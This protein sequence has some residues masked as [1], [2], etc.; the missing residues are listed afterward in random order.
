MTTIVTLLPPEFADWE[1]ALINGAGRSFYGFETR[2]ATPDGA[3]VTSMGGLRV[4][5]DMG[6]AELDP[7]TFDVLLICGGEGWR[8]GAEVGDIAARAHAAGKVVGAI[9]DGVWALAK[10]GL[11]DTRPHTGN[12]AKEVADSGYAG[13]DFYSDAPGAVTSDGIITAAGTAPVAFMAA[14]MTALGKGNAELD[15]YVG[16][17]KAQFENVA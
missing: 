5:P 6:F 17:H 16:L 9:C 1:T 14:V 11:I 4:T 15:Y 7:K 2:Y 13:Q 8:K 3:P 10:T 12:G